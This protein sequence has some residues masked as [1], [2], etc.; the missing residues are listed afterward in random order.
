MTTKQAALID[1]REVEARGEKLHARPVSQ[2]VA[3]LLVIAGTGPLCREC[4][5]RAAKE[6]LSRTDI[7]AVGR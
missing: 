6:T 2:W 1:L 4:A 3:A 5:R 7:L